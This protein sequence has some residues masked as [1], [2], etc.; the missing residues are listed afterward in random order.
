M[1]YT[2]TTSSQSKAPED[3]PPSYNLIAP[4]APLDTS[5][6]SAPARCEIDCTLLKG[7]PPGLEHLLQVSYLLHGK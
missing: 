6:S 1:S 7:V 5:A 2:D 3:E 4:Y